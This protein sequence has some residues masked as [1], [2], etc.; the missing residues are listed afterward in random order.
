MTDQVRPDDAYAPF[1]HRD[2]RLFIALVLISSLSQ[3]SLA[4]AVGWDVYERTGSALALGWLGL[5]QFIPVLTFFLPAGQLADRYDRR[6]IVA[7]SLTFWVAAS[8]LLV[9][10]AA[11]ALPVLWIYVSIAIVG[12]STV[13]NRAGRDA[14]LPQLVPEENLAQAVMWNSTV[15]QTASV[16]GPALAGVLIAAGGSALT[17]Y[18][19][20]LAGMLV[21]I[22]LALLIPKRAPH[23]G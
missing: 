19:F 10:T 21:A 23:G 13:L 3:Q 6:R 1:R 11:H 7:I 2:Y 9:W 5:A 15:F 18:A 8:A 14:L 17:V 12:M 22:V 16:A 4:V 20:N